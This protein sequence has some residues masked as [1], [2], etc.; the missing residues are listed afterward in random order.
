VGK[1]GGVL[2]ERADGAEEK[3]WGGGV[4]PSDGAPVARRSIPGS[5]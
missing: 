4:P 2:G 5:L 3:L 1:E